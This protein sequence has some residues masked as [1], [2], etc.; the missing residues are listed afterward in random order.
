MHRTLLLLT[1]AV[2][3]AAQWQMQDAHTTADL[4]GIHS[5]GGGVAWASG[6]N[7]TILRTEDAGFVWQLC[8]IPPGAEKLDFRGIQAFDNNTAVVMSSGKGDLSR[9][10]KTTDGCQSWKQIFTSPYTPEGFFDA[11]LFTDASH[12]LLF[13]DPSPGALSAEPADAF[14]LRLTTDSG[15]TWAPVETPGRKQPGE[16]LWALRDEAAFAASNS[17]IFVKGHR[18][19]FA[20][21]A[22]RIAYHDLGEGANSKLSTAPAPALG[23]QADSISGEPGQP[24]T[25]FKSFIA[26]IN[27]AAPSAGI[28]SL[29]F[30]SDAVGV[31]VGGDFKAPEDGRATAA[32][33]T[34]GGADW[35]ASTRTPHGYRSSVAYD[36]SHRSWIT[37]GPNGTDVSS[38]DGRTWRPLRPGAVDQPDADRQW[39]ALSLPYAV[40]PHGRIGR[41][42]DDAIR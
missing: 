2:P 25:G 41:L 23:G 3:A 18:F 1:F 26:P 35:T 10:Y 38:D 6:T 30:R 9:L 15:K 5:L 21:S 8:A 34:T 14:R 40:G 28:F 4:R 39:N 31:A 7:G 37:V 17:S 42:R 27:H 22:S 32:F 24:W 20:T 13:G 11:I 29:F 19:W 33:S 12:G 16:G 36:I